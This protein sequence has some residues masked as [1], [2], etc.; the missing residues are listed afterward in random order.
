MQRGAP[1][2]VDVAKRYHTR[3]NLSGTALFAVAAEHHATNLGRKSY[4]AAA[5]A[6]N[7]ELLPHTVSVNEP[8]GAHAE[9]AAIA[10]F[11]QR[12]YEQR[13]QSG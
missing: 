3:E 9:E 11:M 13:L 1:H 12:W 7:G 2:F 4:H 5:I 8:C 10:R 6:L